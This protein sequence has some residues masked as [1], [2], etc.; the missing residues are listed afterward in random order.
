MITVQK[1]LAELK[2]G[3][4]GEAAATE[5]RQ[6]VID[7]WERC[8]ARLW[9]RRVGHVE[10]LHPESDLIKS[11]FLELW[12]VETITKV[13]EKFDAS[14]NWVELPAATYELT[15]KDGYELRKIN[16]N[17]WLASVRVTYTGG[18][19]QEP[20]AHIDGVPDQNRTPGHILR[21]LVMQG[22]FIT[23]VA[24]SDKILVKS[25]NFEQGAGVLHDPTLHPYFAKMAEK[26]MRIA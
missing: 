17:Y 7:T 22:K 24:G 20:A 13:E 23:G 14:S 15:R 26:E 4:K 18:Y 8:T 19:V 10:T 6:E 21:A 9:Q 1:I 3:A 2:L 25:Q 5:I 12:P 11:L 16:G